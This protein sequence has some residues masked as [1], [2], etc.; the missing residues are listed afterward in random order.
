MIEIDTVIALATL[1][2]ASVSLGLQ[3]AA[4]INSMKNDRP[5]SKRRDRFSIKTMR[6]TVIGDPFTFIS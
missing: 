1:V 4:Y 2:I 3:I 6:T 5:T